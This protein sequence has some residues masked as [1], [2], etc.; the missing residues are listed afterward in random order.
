MRPI[1]RCTQSHKALE[2]TKGTNANVQTTEA[3]ANNIGDDSRIEEGH[4]TKPR[5]KEDGNE[6][7]HATMSNMNAAI[8]IINGI[9]GLFEMER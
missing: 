3:S 9:L 4:E 2:V 6:G 7:D 5:D 8:S 1:N